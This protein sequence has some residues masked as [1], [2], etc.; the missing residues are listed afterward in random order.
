M[1]DVADAAIMVASQTQDDL[2]G[3]A[4][5]VSHV[6]PDGVQFSRTA[7]GEVDP[8]NTESL[9]REPSLMSVLNK[10]TSYVDT[11]F[12]YNVCSPA[13]ASPQIEETSHSI[14]ALRKASTIDANEIPPLKPVTKSFC[15]RYLDSFAQK[16]SSKGPKTPMGSPLVSCASSG[17]L[18]RSKSGIM[19]P[20]VSSVCVMASG[21]LVNSQSEANETVPELTNNPSVNAPVNLTRKST[22][23]TDEIPTKDK[24]PE[25]EAEEE[26]METEETNEE[27]ET[28]G[29]DAKTCG[30]ADTSLVTPP[31]P[32]LSP[33]KSLTAAGPMAFPASLPHPGGPA[34]VQIAFSFD[35]TGSM[36]QCIDLVRDQLRDVI[37]RLLGDVPHLQVAVIAHGDYCDA[38]EFYMVKSVDFTNDVN[39]LTQFVNDVGGTGGGDYEECYEYVL[40]YARGL[41]WQPGTQRSLVM[42]GDAIPHEADYFLNAMKLDW[43][44]EADK[45]LRELVSFVKLYLIK[46]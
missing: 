45:L 9:R 7:S 21:P 41:S 17:I 13:P 8:G 31:A 19:I 29:M 10:S 37:Q 6:A 26:A 34:P 44:Q 2:A 30:D 23:P 40:N 43:K 33:V 35:T 3:S 1:I 39:V 12:D 20:P 16:S 18:T 42:I 27:R 36:S 28:T 14:P 24:T 22:H 5:S 25:A 15:A 4:D 46:P 38:A 11:V 32:I